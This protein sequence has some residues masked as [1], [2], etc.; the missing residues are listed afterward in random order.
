MKTIRGNILSNFMYLGLFMIVYFIMTPMIFYV[1]DTIS[2]T[3]PLSSYPIPEST[4]AILQFLIYVLVP[5]MAIVWTILS[6]SQPNYE[7]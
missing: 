5:I 4:T 1:I 7:Q 2:S 6:S 3:A